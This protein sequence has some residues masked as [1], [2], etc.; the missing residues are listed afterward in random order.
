MAGGPPVVEVPLQG[1]A[2]ATLA[3]VE[4]LGVILAS[5]LRGAGIAAP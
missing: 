2:P 3:E 1:D 5:A 4:S